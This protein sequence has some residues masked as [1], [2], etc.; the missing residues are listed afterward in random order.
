M[1]L[2][3]ELNEVNQARAIKATLENECYLDYE[4]HDFTTK[5]FKNILE[6]LGY[7]DI[8]S[9]FS[10]FYSQGDGAS[11]EARYSYEKQSVNKI[12]DYASLDKE[13][14]RI[15]KELFNIQNKLRY[16]LEA[17]ITT[18]G[19]YC[20]EM[21]MRC[22]CQSLRGFI[23]EDTV[24]NKEEDMLDISR[25]LAIWYYKQLNEQ[26]NYL[27]SDEVVKKY[28]IANELEFDYED[29]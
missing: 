1:K 16:D 23:N 2:F 11:F 24:Q 9:Y 15:A 3:N 10:G 8:K 14:H 12:I 6:I 25:D 18:G 21:T 20:H 22:E 4:W 7:Y 29:N 27:M 17:K 28:I 5:D 26:Y 13:L 19:N